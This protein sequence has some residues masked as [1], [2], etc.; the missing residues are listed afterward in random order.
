MCSI[1][2]AVGASAY[3][4]GVIESS[5]KSGHNSL[6]GHRSPRSQSMEDLSYIVVD[7]LIYQLWINSHMRI[8]VSLPHRSCQRVIVDRRTQTSKA[9]LDE[10]RQFYAHRLHGFTEDSQPAIHSLS[11]ITQDFTRWADVVVQCIENYIQ[12][13]SDRL[14]SYLPDNTRRR[15]PPPLLRCLSCFISVKPRHL[16]T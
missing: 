16:C 14:F 9:V 3:V 12:R 6:A 7:L 5:V 2:E 1:Q 11:M 13:V 10:S 8:C 15:E 4:T